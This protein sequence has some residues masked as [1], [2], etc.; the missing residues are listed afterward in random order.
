M[1]AWWWLIPAVVVGIA[2]GFFILAGL[3]RL[4]LADDR[5]EWELD[6]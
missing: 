5:G 2:A 1:I 4:E 6:D 3:Q